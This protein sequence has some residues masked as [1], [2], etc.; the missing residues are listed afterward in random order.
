[1]STCKLATKKNKKNNGALGHQ[2]DFLYQA[3]EEMCGVFFFKINLKVSL[4]VKHPPKCWEEAF[5][6][7]RRR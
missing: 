7:E 5:Q 4:K 1:M 3:I 6:G 2:K